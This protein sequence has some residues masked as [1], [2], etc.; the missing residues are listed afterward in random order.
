MEINL[1]VSILITIGIILI[2]DIRYKEIVFE[3]KRR[4]IKVE[5]IK[6]ITKRVNKKAK[7]NIRNEILKTKHF[8]AI[9]NNEN[10]F[11]LILIISFSLSAI[12]ITISILINNLFLIPVIGTGCFFMP[13]WYVKLTYSKQRQLLNEELE[14]TLS[15]ITSTYL[16]NENIISAVEENI[17][18]FQPITKKIFNSFLI[19]NELITSNQEETLLKLKDKIESEVFKEW[20]DGIILCQEDKNLKTILVPIVNKFSEMRVVSLEL[21]TI[22]AEPIKEFITMC[23]LILG[24]IPLFYFINKEWY[25]ILVYTT[26][27]KIILSISFI[28]V[29]IAIARVVKL[30][31][32]VEYKR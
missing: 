5:N 6:T 24:I 18:Y 21:E 16:R 4:K 22:L 9:S 2:F 13:F 8:L 12:G 23:G 29:F 30:S 10:K 28:V 7:R 17:E 3:M 14:S 25:K 1:I 19:D 32:P 11:K 20:V 26:S 31:E 15:V 27:G